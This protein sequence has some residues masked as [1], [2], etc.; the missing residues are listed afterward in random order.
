MQ[1]CKDILNIFHFASYRIDSIIETIVKE[2]TI[3]CSLWKSDASIEAK[4]TIW[5]LLRGLIL[6][7]AKVNGGRP[8][9]F[10]QDF[11]EAFLIMTNVKHFADYLNIYFNHFVLW[12]T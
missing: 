6:I 2:W 7:N 10:F 12:D 5:N 9:I 1:I 4:T 11:C 3:F 8:T